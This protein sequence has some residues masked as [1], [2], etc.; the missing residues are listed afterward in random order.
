MTITLKFNRRSEGMPADTR[1]TFLV[2]VS[3]CDVSRLPIGFL[4][5]FSEEN[6]GLHDHLRLKRKGDYLLLTLWTRGI[7]WTAMRM[8]TEES[9]RFFNNLI[10]F[11]IGIA[12]A[13]CPSR[14]G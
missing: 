1:Y 2:G 6:G 14:K 9:D 3:K 12:V 5:E 4:H 7:S 8:S 11:E 10:G 13:G